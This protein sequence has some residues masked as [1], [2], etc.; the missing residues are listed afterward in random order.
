VTIAE[1]VVGDLLEGS[2]HLGP[3]GPTPGRHHRE[4]IPTRDLGGLVDVRDL[5]QPLSQLLQL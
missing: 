4:L 5:R 1:L 2:E 3:L